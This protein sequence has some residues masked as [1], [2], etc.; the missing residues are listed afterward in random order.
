MKLLIKGIK[1]KVN[2]YTD[3][4]AEGIRWFADITHKES[5]PFRAGLYFH[6][7]TKLSNYKSKKSI[8]DAIERNKESL[9]IIPDK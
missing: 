8:S 6:E 2:L 7:E 4:N 9:L 1:Y 3:E 5:K